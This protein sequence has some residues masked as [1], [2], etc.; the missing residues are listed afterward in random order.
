MKLHQELRL[1]TVDTGLKMVKSLRN[2]NS[3][4][5]V[6]DLFFHKALFVNITKVRS[7]HVGWYRRKLKTEMCQ[8]MT[9]YTG[10]AVKEYTGIA[11]KEYTGTAVKEYTGIAVKEY[12]GIAVK[13]YT[14]IAVK[15]YTGIAVK[16]YTGIAVKEYTGI[17]VK[18]YTCT[19]EVL[20]RILAREP[21]FLITPSMLISRCIRGS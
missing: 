19:R 8:K 21:I 12:T 9:E 16:Q 14:G 1:L 10:I 2:T 17:A 15:E 20:V 11:V 7:F 6:F 13:E 4:V 18:E 5:F 3:R